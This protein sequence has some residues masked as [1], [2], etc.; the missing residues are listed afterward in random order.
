[1]RLGVLPETAGPA[2]VSRT[3]WRSRTNRRD[4]Q[5]LLEPR[6]MIALNTD[7]ETKKLFAVS[8]KFR[9]DVSSK[10]S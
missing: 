1:M 4:A 3:E 5:L 7:C 8:V 2:S 6:N 10:N 9:F